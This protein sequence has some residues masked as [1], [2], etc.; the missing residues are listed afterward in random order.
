MIAFGIRTR[1]TAAIA[2][3]VIVSGLIISQAVTHRYTHSLLQTAKAQSENLAHNLALDAADKILLNDIVGLRKLLDDRMKTNP[4]VAYLF[5]VDG[6]AVVS[7]TFE[8]GV[9]VEL[10]AANRP[11]DDRQGRI[12]KIVSEKGVRYLDVSRPIFG[13]QAG[14]LRAGFFEKAYLEDAA[15]LRLQISLLTVAVLL[16]CLA[17]G[18]LFVRHI[19]RQLVRLTEAVEH[20][21]EAH[22]ELSLSIETRDE[23]GR[24]S[25]AFHKMIG[26][27]KD[28]TGRLKSTAEQ[29]E[30]T[31]RE[32]EQAYRQ[33]RIAFEIARELGSVSDLHEICRLLLER[34]KTIIT[35]RQIVLILFEGDGRRIWVYSVEDVQAVR[36]TKRSIDDLASACT[37]SRYMS[38]EKFPISVPEFQQA[39]TVAGFP[40]RHEEHLIGA[41]CVGCPGDCACVK[42]EMA[43]IEL[44]LSQ[45]AGAIRRAAV[46]ENE[47]RGLRLRIEQASGY[48]GFVGKDPKMHVVYKLIEDVA[49]SDATV[50]ILG[51]SGT[52]KELAARAIHEQSPRGNAPFVIINCSAYPSTLLE[53]ELFG[54]EKGAFTGASAQKKGRFEQAEGGTIFLDEIGEIPS[55]A[56]VKLL[57]VLQ[58]RT[59]ERVG[60]TRT[61]AV[62]V[63]ILAA[64]HRDLL[65]DVKRGRFREDLYYR[66][67]V[68][69]IHLPPL[70]DRRNDIPMLAR[71]FL[72][73]FRAIQ[74]KE[75]AD[76][77]PD[78]MR[79]LLDHP[80][81]GNVRELENTVEHAV[82]LARGGLIQPSD[83]PV[84][85]LEPETADPGESA[86]SLQDTEK[87]HLLEA[88]DA[89]KWNKAETARRLGI[90]RSTLYSKMKK[91]RIRPRQPH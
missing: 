18:H 55:T 78:A 19:T 2:G 45:S 5:I 68:I 57:R 29:L 81:P 90:G 51:E 41:M 70:R 71:H 27:I 84:Q 8:T 65:Q 24:L 13:G 56:Q 54:Y 59:F 7:H 88:L 62:D 36:M 3:I 43:V 31:N 86:R 80:W 17:A 44:V 15:G 35:C 23:V 33:A 30:A 21:D 1:L 49:P 73:R 9:P 76:F 16:I 63:R 67:N 87:G 64:T 26:R 47:V 12:E 69:P 10:I 53:S 28:F 46:Y 52:G 66:L 83:L 42:N 91:Y 37:D 82:V 74:E 58:H 85:V 11:V 48:S 79:L 4:E 75:I 77:S 14:M 60:G 89:C 25:S 39:E 20:I 34:L 61:L 32:L 72:P 6:D 38:K 40:I 22:M 50:L